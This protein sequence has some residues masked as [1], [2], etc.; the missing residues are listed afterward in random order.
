M[1]ER[2][3]HLS[4]DKQI[5]EK[6]LSC[7][8]KYPVGQVGHGISTGL[9]KA[10][11]NIFIASIGLWSTRFQSISHCPKVFNLSNGLVD[12]HSTYTH[13]FENMFSSFARQ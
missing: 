13:T 3:F 11:A 9:L 2:L 5:L 12:V 8:V 10:R 6:H 4:M 1:Q 7:F